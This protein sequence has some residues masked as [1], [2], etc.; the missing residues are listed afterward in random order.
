MFSRNK[1]DLHPSLFLLLASFSKNASLLRD[2]FAL[3]SRALH[4]ATGSDESQ[5]MRPKDILRI[6]THPEGKHSA[7]EGEK[8][9]QSRR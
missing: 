1:F 4:G 9:I 3:L 5:S 2:S 7:S 8:I 6:F